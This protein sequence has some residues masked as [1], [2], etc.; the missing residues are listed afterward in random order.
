VRKIFSLSLVFVLLLTGCAPNFQKQEEVV[1]K[2]KDSEEKAIIPKY[3]ISDDYYRTILPF[4]ASEARGLVVNNLN[5]RYDLVEFET[6]LMR[7]AQNTFDP[8]KYLFQEGQ[9]VKK[10]KIAL[11]LNRQFTPEQLKEQK[12]EESENIGLNPL[13]NGNGDI[14][15]RNQKN[16]IYL[17]HILEH[18]YLIKGDNEKVSLGGIVIGLALNSV[19]SKALL[20]D[21]FRFSAN[22]SMGP[23]PR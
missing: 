10:E 8:E 22:K 7:V 18:D 2:Q 12:L 4:K 23:I 11:W 5:S 13:D 17:A 21:D 16:P 20:L 3:K 1:Q 15:E 9:Y 6:G 19:H 14:A